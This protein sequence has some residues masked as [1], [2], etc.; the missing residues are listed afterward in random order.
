MRHG[1]CLRQGKE[2]VSFPASTSRQVALTR[3]WKEEL[4]PMPR[5][6]MPT[7][8]LWREVE[9]FIRDLHTCDYR[10]AAKQYEELIYWAYKQQDL[11]LSALRLEAC[12]AATAYLYFHLVGSCEDPSLPWDGWNELGYAAWDDRNTAIC[13]VCGHKR[14]EAEVQPDGP[15]DEEGG[16]LVCPN[17]RVPMLSDRYHDPEPWLEANFVEEDA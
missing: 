16:E 8:E 13:P 3:A 2:Y 9:L 4:V 12:R 1:C 14:S 6:R 15:D 7:R 17:T 11:P 5:S 10:E